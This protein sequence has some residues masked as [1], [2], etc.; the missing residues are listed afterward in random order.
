MITAMLVSIA[1]VGLCNMAGVIA[2]MLGRD[3]GHWA[4]CAYA[5]AV[6]ILAGVIW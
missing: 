1:I 5:L 3:Y 4:C 6:G 2:E